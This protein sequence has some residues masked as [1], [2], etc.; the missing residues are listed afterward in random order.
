MWWSRF[1]AVAVLAVLLLPAAVAAAPRPLVRSSHGVV[2]QFG[3]HYV[4]LAVASKSGFRVSIATTSPDGGVSSPMIVEQS[5]L[6][7]FTPISKGDWQ[8]VQTSF[9]A[10]QINTTSAAFQ[11]LDNKGSVIIDSPKLSSALSASAG[12]QEDVCQ[13]AVPGYDASGGTRSKSAPNGLQ[14]Q[15]QTSCCQACNAASDCDFFVFA[16]PSAPDPSG[17]NCWLLHDV[18]GMNPRQGRISGGNAPSPP[19]VIDFTLP[20]A[21]Q[22]PLY[23]G[24]GGGAGDP[25]THTSSSASVANTHFQ[26]PYYWSTDGYS[27]LG[28]SPAPFK[29]GDVQSYPAAWVFDGSNVMWTIGGDPQ[30]DL[31]L[32]PAATAYDS[33]DC[34]W[35]VTGR[36]QLP[37]R[38]AFGFLAGRW[39]WVNATYIHQMLSN[40]RSG[41]FPA[42]AFISDFEWYTPEPDYNLPNSG[43]PTFKD[44]TYNNI[45]FP[46]PVQ[47]L[48]DYRK[49]LNFR[50]GGIRKPRL[51]NSQLLVMAKNKGWLIDSSY[52][53]GGRNL[54]YSIADLRTWYYEQHTHFLKEGVEFWWNDE[55]ETQYFTF[56]WW[57]EA[58]YDGLAAYDKSK[59]FFTINRS[60]SPGMSRFGLSVWTG[61]ISVSF[62]SMAQQVG[63]QINWNM[64]GASF[65]TCDTGGFSG[66]DDTPLLL[67]RWYFVSAFL[68]IMRVHSTDSDMPHFPFLYGQQAGNAMRKALELRYQ[69]LP[70]HYSLAHGMYT[71]GRP[72]FRGMFFDYPTDTVCQT[73]ATQWMDGDYL[74]V[75][76]VLS[77]DNSS[78]AYLPADTWYE[79]N[80]TT[81]HTG[82]TYI[83]Q[84][85][86]ALDHVP[87]FVK[88]GGI[89]PLGPVIQYT[90]LLPGG[91]LTVHVYD[92]A[93]GA[94]ELVEDDGAT[95]EYTSG[96]TLKS[97]F[98]Y[99]SASQT[100]SWTK[101]GSYSGSDVFTNVQALLFTPQGVKQGSLTDF[102]KPGTIKF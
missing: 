28:V 15:T 4:E 36:P 60:Y 74:L 39:G 79:F 19:P 47:Q 95:L 83:N 59:R 101:S 81:T 3:K 89:L 54:N 13:Q 58:Q 56:H 33:L 8:G 86:V 57:N 20:A 26:A 88:Q 25:I 76:P 1:L 44:F 7:S 98:S 51:G 72:V 14:N 65:V 90:D 48:Q 68:G 27:A 97:H 96:A 102:T 12:L 63:Y 49:N 78:S 35:D 67:T 37:P 17:A 80:T 100:L 62:E 71:S 24:A 77:Q 23:Y 2:V 41:N 6:P 22:S 93:D 16:L 50:F 21:S 29:E 45:T 42:D 92:G 94:F 99:S 73:I 5:S 82:P 70:M 40:F 31:Y 18:P 10:I 53:G 46:N 87:L 64:A 91:P 69:L 84:T 30:V 34:L 11:M 38:Y 9:G 75:S 85:N 43:S 66:P 32:M 52:T 61:D 55:G